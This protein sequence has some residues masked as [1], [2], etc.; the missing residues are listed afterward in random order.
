MCRPPPLAPLAVLA[1]TFD[2]NEDSTPC[3]HNSCCCC[4]CYGRQLLKRGLLHWPLLLHL[5]DGGNLFQSMLQ[6]LLLLPSKALLHSSQASPA[7]MT[8]TL[9]V[10]LAHV[11]SPPCHDHFRLSSRQ[12]ETA[13]S[14][15]K[16]PYG[17]KDGQQRCIKQGQ[18]AGSVDQHRA[19][20]VADLL[21]N[22]APE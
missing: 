20:L 7:T 5:L 9:L 3:K 14:H 18:L 22:W 11:I 10:K 8:S 17:P 15:C 12:F 21:S 4:C 1:S 13:R 16:Q 19:S 2:V 6:Y